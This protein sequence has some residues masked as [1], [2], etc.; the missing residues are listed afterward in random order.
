MDTKVT[1]ERLY[2]DLVTTLKSRLAVAEDK[3][4][5]TKKGEQINIGT[6]ANGVAETVRPLLESRSFPES[7]VDQDA[8]MQPLDFSHAAKLE[9]ECHPLMEQA[10]VQVRDGTTNVLVEGQYP[11]SVAQVIVKAILLGR[12]KFSY[13]TE[14]PAAETAL[15]GFSKW[16]PKVL[17]KIAM[18]CGMS[19]VGTSYEEDV[20]NAVLD[21]LHLDT[22]ISSPEFYGDVRLH[23]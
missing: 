23:N 2:A 14:I 19:A 5:Q 7:F 13:P 4:V 9:I 22:H 17:N 11:R 20:Y 6:V 3:D 1:L 10:L 21:T 12:R 15:K 16:F 8:N 18:G